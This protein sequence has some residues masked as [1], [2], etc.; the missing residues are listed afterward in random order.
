MI[1][2]AIATAT[3][4]WADLT[5]RF[6]WFALF[7]TLAFGAVGF[8]DDWLKIARKNPRGCRRGRS[9]SGCRWPASRLRSRSR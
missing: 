9:I 1:L 8:V 2:G 4:L 7:V 3:L 5:N 6:V